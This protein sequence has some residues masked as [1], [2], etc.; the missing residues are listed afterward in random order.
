VVVGH[1]IADDAA[2]RCAHCCEKF[3]GIN[4]KVRS[5]LTLFYIFIYINNL[6]IHCLCS[7]VDSTTVACVVRFFPPSLF[8]V[9]FALSFFSADGGPGGLRQGTCSAPSASN[10]ASPTPSWG[11]TTRRAARTATS[12]SPSPF[13]FSYEVRSHFMGRVRWCVSSRV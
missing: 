5:S 12:S 11:W 9:A 1:W 10:G 2:P 3:T 8:F 13:P 4:R 6:D 7:F